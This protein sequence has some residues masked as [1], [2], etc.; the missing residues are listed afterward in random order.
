MYSTS[1]K[2]WLKSLVVD[3]ILIGALV[4]G[5]FYA[6][7]HVFQVAVFV[8]WWIAILGI[9]ATLLMLTLPVVLEKAVEALQGKVDFLKAHQ[10][11]ASLDPDDLAQTEK[12]LNDLKK[13]LEKAWPE[14]TVRRFAVSNTYLA[15]HWFSDAVVWVLLVIAG[16][17]VLASFEVISFLL[18]CIVIGV[19]RKQYT[20][21]FAEADKVNEELADHR[22]AVA[23]RGQIDTYK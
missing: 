1:A 2:T 7:P 23:L 10:T 12:K 18:S 3:S 5:L 19:A 9:G 21:R 6:V 20:E 4:A 13:I 11:F 15:Y 16:H 8:L 17:P 14:K 22:K